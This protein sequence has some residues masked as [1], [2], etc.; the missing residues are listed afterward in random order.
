MLFRY[1]GRLP[2][3]KNLH[4]MLD[5]IAAKPVENIQQALLFGFDVFFRID[6]TINREGTFFRHDVE[7]R[8]T[9][10]LPAHHQNR[11]SRCL[12][13][14]LKT[15]FALLYFAP[16]LIEFTRNDQHAFECIDTLVTEPN[17]CRLTGYMHPQRDCAAVRIPNY[18]RS[19]LGRQHSN[20]AVT[21]IRPLADATR[22]PLTSCFL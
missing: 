17:V 19:G 16:Q 22:A 21:E 14:Y 8:A 12:R 5:A 10:A 4:F 18:S 6:T 9:P 3:L 7:I 20:A 2:L 11:A 1:A 13:T 15:G